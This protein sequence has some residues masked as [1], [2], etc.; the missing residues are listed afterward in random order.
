MKLTCSDVHL[1]MAWL[2]SLPVPFSILPSFTGAPLKAHSP[3]TAHILMSLGA[4]AQRWREEQSLQQKEQPTKQTVCLLCQ[5]A[6]Q[7]QQDTA[8]PTCCS[9][10]SGFQMQIWVLA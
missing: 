7:P 5:P 9:E 10:H 2:R 3:L 8:A 4:L 6:P 1:P